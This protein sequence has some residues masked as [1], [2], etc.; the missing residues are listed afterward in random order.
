MPH[1][2]EMIVAADHVEGFQAYPACL[3]GRV[4]KLLVAP[5]QREVVA[6]TQEEFADKVARL[7][8]GDAPGGDVR[9]IKR[10]QEL[11]EPPVAVAM[12]VHALGDLEKLD[13]LDGFMQGLRR[14]FRN[15][16]THC[17]DFCVDAARLRISLRCL[18]LPGF[19]RIA[20]DVLHDAQGD[21][22]GGPEVGGA[23]F[24]ARFLEL[25]PVAADLGKEAA[26]AQFQ[27]DAQ[28]RA[29][30]GEADAPRTE[31]ARRIAEIMHLLRV[32][33]GARFIE[34]P[35][36]IA[37]N[38]LAGVDHRRAMGDEKAVVPRPVFGRVGQPLFFGRHVR[39][40]R[41]GHAGVHTAIVV[42]NIDAVVGGLLACGRGECLG[43]SR[44]VID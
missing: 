16:R 30:V 41:I 4:A 26:P 1:D 23:L 28:V 21:I 15:V 38:P 34:L 25:A 33:E 40:K 11:V 32:T 10:L 6:I 20:A 35:M 17:G 13:P 5:A 18:Q 44:P 22:L 43:F 12:A 19:F 27:A 42:A 36:E 8:P 31:L 3:A 39:D 29:G 7:F 9:V 37:H 24:V 2:A 14:F